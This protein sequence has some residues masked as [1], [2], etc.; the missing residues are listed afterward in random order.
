MYRLDVLCNCFLMC[1]V[2]HQS[3]MRTKIWKMWHCWGT[4]L[5]CQSWDFA[6][7]PTM[8]RLYACTMYTFVLELLNGA[9]ALLQLKQPYLWIKRPPVYTMMLLRI[10]CG[11]S[12]STR[13]CFECTAMRN[14]VQCGEWSVERDRLLCTHCVRSFISFMCLDV[15]MLQTDCQP[16]RF[17]NGPPVYKPVSRFVIRLACF[18]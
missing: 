3:G 1:L 15:D 5:L 18:W 8:A 11:C 14:C 13:W 12:T 10:H 7:Q 6:R 4:G 17:I 2:F 9:V 16:D